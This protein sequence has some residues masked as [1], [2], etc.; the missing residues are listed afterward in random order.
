MKVLKLEVHDKTSF[1]FS[2]FNFENAR[3]LTNIYLYVDAELSYVGSKKNI[4]IHGIKKLPGCIRVL[5]VEDESEGKILKPLGQLKFV[6]VDMS[7]IYTN[8][9]VKNK[10]LHAIE[11]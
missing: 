2:R 7:G 4:S 6:G 8:V 9:G 11:K 10:F 3:D 5:T 1:D